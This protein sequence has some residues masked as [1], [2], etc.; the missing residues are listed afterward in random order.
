MRAAIGGSSPARASAS[1]VEFSE[2]LFAVVL[3]RP[4][5]PGHKIV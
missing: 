2:F 5:A 4:S 1:A 3:I